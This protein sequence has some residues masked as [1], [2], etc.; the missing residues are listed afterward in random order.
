MFLFEILNCYFNDFSFF[1]HVSFYYDFV[2]G[3]GRGVESH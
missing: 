1:S 3:P 2:A